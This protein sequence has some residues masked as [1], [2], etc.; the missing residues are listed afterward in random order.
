M[1]K[2]ISVLCA[3]ILMFS[4]SACGSSGG[5]SQEEYDAL[6]AELEELKAEQNSE[7]TDSA[8]T[9]IN[10]EINENEENYNDE[11]EIVAEYTVASWQN[12]RPYHFIIIKNN[13]NVTLTVRS[14]S[15][16]YDADEN[17]IGAGDAD[18]TALGSG[19]TSVLME[20]MRAEGTTA[21][22]DTDITTSVSDYYDSITQDLS[23]TQID[24]ENGAIFQVTNNS[25]DSAKN[26]TGYAFF[27][28]D[29]DP[30]SYDSYSFY[31]E[32]FELKPGATITKQFDSRGDFDSVQ[33]FLDGTRAK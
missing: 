23:Y 25:S 8:D 21:K 2:F 28:K 19:C 30:V 7:S 15:M 24:I 1:K 4:M 9:E 11:V 14:S 26:V 32:D 10:E 16:A 3:L 12:S 22:Y 6:L 18:I 17:I 5:V 29:G 31:D 33:F 20:V 13:S 27:M